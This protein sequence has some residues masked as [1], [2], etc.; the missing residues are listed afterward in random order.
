MAFYRPRRIEARRVP[1]RGLLWENRTDWGMCDIADWCGG[2][3]INDEGEDTP[4]RLDESTTANVGDY[5]VKIGHEFC[6]MNEKQF[7]AS[8]EE[9][10]EGE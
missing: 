4:I 10:E 5:I 3:V 8:Y 7:Q 2:S 1:Q 6:V 9:I